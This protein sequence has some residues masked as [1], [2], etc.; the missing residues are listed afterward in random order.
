MM[1][2]DRQELLCVNVDKVYDWIVNEASF[3]L[4]LV[5]EALPDGLECDDLNTADVTCEVSPIS[6][7]ILE[8]EDRTFIIFFSMDP[9][10]M[11]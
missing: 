1:K 6:V 4:T 3:E 2:S 10:E 8:R 11:L 9:G 7:D 5:D